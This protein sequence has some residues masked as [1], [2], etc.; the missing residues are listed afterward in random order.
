LRV[1]YDRNARLVREFVDA[2]NER[3]AARFLATLSPDVAL[4]TRRG[5]LSGKAAASAWFEKP[6]E[7]LEMKVEPLRFVVGEPWIV[8]F[9]LM[10]YF[11]RETGELAEAKPGGALWEIDDAGIAAWEPLDDPAARLAELGAEGFDLSTI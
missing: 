10:R 11:W 8:G 7:H 9:A 4:R 1:S 6:L 3:D 2:F 5:V